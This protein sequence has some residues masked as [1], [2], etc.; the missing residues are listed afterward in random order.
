MRRNGLTYYLVR[1]KKSVCLFRFEF[2]NGNLEYIMDYEKIG[3]N[4]ASYVLPMF[5]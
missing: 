3:G 1:E 2:K 4:K 5:T